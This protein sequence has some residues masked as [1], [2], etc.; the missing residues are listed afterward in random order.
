M[1]AAEAT[2]TVVPPVALKRPDKK[3]L[4]GP[5]KQRLTKAHK[6]AAAAEEKLTAALD[7]DATTDE[8][9]DAVQ[10]ERDEAVH[11]WNGTV[12]EMIDGQTQ[13]VQGNEGELDPN[14]DPDPDPPEHPDGETGSEVRNDGENP[15]DEPDAPRLDDQEPPI[16]PNAPTSIDTSAAPTPQVPHSQRDLEQRDPRPSPTDVASARRPAVR[17]AQ[18]NIPASAKNLDVKNGSSQVHETIKNAIRHVDSNTV[19]DRENLPDNLVESNDALAA[20]LRQN[21]SNEAQIREVQ[22]QLDILLKERDKWQEARHV[23]KQAADATA[24]GAVKVHGMDVEGL[25][26]CYASRVGVNGRSYGD[27]MLFVINPASGQIATHRLEN[28]Q[29]REHPKGIFTIVE[30]AG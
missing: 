23:L 1:S 27:V 19:I 8:Q 11:A 15:E 21:I 2:A 29:L 3:G 9:L 25:I 28:A 22:N 13:T 10:A 30:S 20:S 4:S 12:T 17:R 6:K 5:E 26:E 14:A 18:T 7:N 16:D 24:G